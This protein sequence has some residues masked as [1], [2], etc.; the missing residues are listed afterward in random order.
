MLH[1]KTIQLRYLGKV[2]M[3]IALA[4]PISYVFSF[5]AQVVFLLRTADSKVTS[6]S[7]LIT[8][9]LATT[10]LFLAICAST[11]ERILLLRKAKWMAISLVMIAT[12]IVLI[13]YLLEIGHTVYFNWLAYI[14]CV[15][16][17]LF[18]YILIKMRI[19]CIMGLTKTSENKD[20]EE[21]YPRNY[22]FQIFRIFDPNVDG[23]E[24]NT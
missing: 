7:L 19:I 24:Q 15:P 12:A 11:I 20:T 16:I 23:N 9:I 10:T 1:E 14:V 2:A 18:Y 4:I 21:R 3:L 8:F 6:L 22:Y 17:Y 13:G 5:I